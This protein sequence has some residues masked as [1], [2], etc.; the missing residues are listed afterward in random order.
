[1]S[2]GHRSL[3][4]KIA[5]IIPLSYLSWFLGKLANLPLPQPFARWSI[6]IFAK[7]YGIDLTTATEPMQSFRS[8]GEFFTRDIK[9]EERPRGAG[10]ICP[11]DGTLRQYGELTPGQPITQ[12]KGREY[13]LEAL[14]GDDEFTSQLKC[15]ALWNFYLSPADAH[16][17]FAPVEGKIVRTVHIP[18]KLWPVNDW[19]LHSVDGLFA[20]NER[21]VTFIETEKGLVAVVMIGAT[22]VGRIALRYMQLETNLRPWQAKSPKRFDHSNLYVRAGDK[23]GTFKMGSSVIV[24]AETYRASEPFESKQ[25][26][27]IPRKVLYGQGL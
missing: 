21:I 1:M 15:A 22:N 17:I 24:I 4:V 7:A 11:V 18:G 2:V 20:I 19:A 26:S 16:H 8:I 3:V 25:Q 5:K 13:T 10:F 14:L 9:A 6:Y 12:V 23:L 27:G